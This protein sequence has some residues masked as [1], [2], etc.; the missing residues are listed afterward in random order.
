MERLVR[1]RGCH[2]L[3]ILGE[4]LPEANRMTWAVHEF[5]TMGVMEDSSL[6]LS[7][8]DAQIDREPRGL[9]LQFSELLSL[10]CQVYQVTNGLF[11][12]CYDRSRL[13]RLRLPRLNED[14][15]VLLAGADLLVSAFD[16]T[17]WFVGG[18]VE[19]IGRIEETFSNVTEMD[20]A[21]TSPLTCRS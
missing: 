10:A 13:P 4:L 16:G 6:R 9:E 11:V 14:D 15:E 8:L 3:T 2:P 20:P 5:D 17:M 12:G 19:V 18:S 21:K 1:V 7:D